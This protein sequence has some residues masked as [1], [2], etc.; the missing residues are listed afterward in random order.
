MYRIVF[1]LFADTLKLSIIISKDEEVAI[2]QPEKSLRAQ[3]FKKLLK[4]RKRLDC[5][6]TFPITW[7]VFEGFDSDL[8]LF[9]YAKA[10]PA[11][12][13]IWNTA[14]SKLQRGSS[15]VEILHFL[16]LRALAEALK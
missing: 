11:D 9:E 1:F 14:I 4:K 8:K 6:F 2:F 15:Y 13:R 3:F 16:E 10:I 12:S 7:C 5:L